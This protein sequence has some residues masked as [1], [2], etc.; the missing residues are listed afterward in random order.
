MPVWGG[1]GGG[2]V[3]GLDGEGE[4]VGGVDVQGGDLQEGG[5]SLQ[6][7][8]G[9]ADAGKA[10]AV[11]GLPHA[12][13]SEVGVSW[14][15]WK[16]GHAVTQPKP[17]LRSQAQHTCQPQV[18]VRQGDHNSIPC[19][20]R[21]LTHPRQPQCMSCHVLPSDS[22][23]TIVSFVMSTYADPPLLSYCASSPSIFNNRLPEHTKYP[24]SVDLLTQE[25]LQSEGRVAVLGRKACVRG[26]DLTLGVTQYR[27][28]APLGAVGDSRLIAPHH[29]PHVLVG[30]VVEGEQR[31]GWGVVRGPINLGALSPDIAPIPHLTAQAQM[32]EMQRGDGSELEV[33]CWERSCIWKSY[34]GQ[35]V[36]PRCPLVC[37]VEYQ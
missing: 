32:Q 31:V 6:T 22:T 7:L 20:F 13:A 11:P 33:Q 25:P 12:D 23:I 4:G 37:T 18:L 29:G 30:R 35:L 21:D 5:Q 16:F 8:H 15:V 2:G 1:E 27:R 34:F 36:Q 26:E 3:R 14:A 17:P 10:L 19:L 24:G 9:Q 28:R